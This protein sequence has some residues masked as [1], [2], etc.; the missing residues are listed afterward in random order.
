MRDG[1]S[2]SGL[3]GVARLCAVQTMYAADM[4][5]VDPEKLAEKSSSR[6]EICITED[7][8]LFEMDHEFYDRLLR[9]A[10]ENL[11]AVDAVVLKNLA[12]NWRFDRL[13]PLMKSVLRLGVTELLY[14]LDVPRNVILNE[15]I[16]ISKAFFDKPEVAFVNGL[17]DSVLKGAP[18]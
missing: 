3:R 9:I 2:K 1:K 14:L 16:E 7:E 12:G 4:E 17:L 11:V 13:S 18:E 10:V 6:P 8:S 5:N 15:Y